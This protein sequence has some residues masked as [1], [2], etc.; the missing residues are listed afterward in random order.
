MV[1]ARVLAQSLHTRIIELLV[2]SGMRV[3]FQYRHSR[4]MQI[5]KTAA[6]ALKIYLE[7]DWLKVT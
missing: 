3:G 5:W 2:F 6:I 4:G 1:D 7:S